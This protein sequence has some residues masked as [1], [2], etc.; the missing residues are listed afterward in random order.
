VDH[1][2]PKLK[3]DTGA[4][5]VHECSD[6]E[7][8]HFASAVLSDNPNNVHEAQFKEPRQDYRTFHHQSFISKPGHANDQD[9]DAHAT[10]A[11]QHQS[12]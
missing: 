3:P 4:D 11:V 6:Q 1:T 5:E 2:N 7:Q 9:D 12:I 10:K 8:E